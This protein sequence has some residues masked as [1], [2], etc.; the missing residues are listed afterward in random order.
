MQRLYSIAKH[1]SRNSFWIGCGIIGVTCIVFWFIAS[2]EL[3]RRN[4]KLTNEIKANFETGSKILNVTAEPEGQIVHPNQKT[5]D[6]MQ[7]AIAKTTESIKNA[8]ERRCQ[9][10]HDLLHPTPEVTEKNDGIASL[11]AKLQPAEAHAGTRIP[12]SLLAVYKQHVPTVMPR[13]C[14]I[15]GTRWQ[16]D[17][18]PESKKDREET[19]R[20]VCRWKSQNQQLWK[21]KLTQFAARDDNTTRENLPSASQLMML[22]QDLRLLE[23]MFHVVRATNSENGRMAR[24]NGVASIKKI[25][26][27]VFGREAYSSLGNIFE[28]KPASSSGRSSNRKPESESKIDFKNQPAFHARY[29]DKSGSY[30]S[31]TVASDVIANVNSLPENNLDL[32]VVKRIPFRIALR[33][34][35]RKIGDYIAVCENSAIPFRITQTRI[36]VH[37]PNEK[38]TLNG[39]DRGTSVRPKRDLSANTAGDIDRQKGKSISDKLGPVEARINYDVDA[40]FYGYAKIYSPVNE[41]RLLSGK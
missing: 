10:Q 40:E 37:D 24:S 39:S 3:D 2:S 27:V 29:I 8:W 32:V 18:Q 4:A 7:Q 9:Q 12:E 16:P 6:Q 15:I 20:I 1:L 11:L 22:E 38:F 13:V 28:I 31:G 34:D 17:K 25:D 21:T 33:I 36:N 30:I 26:Y 35:E 19:E 5:S 23:G 41:Q 14:K